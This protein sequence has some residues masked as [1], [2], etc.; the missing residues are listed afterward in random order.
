MNK[1]PQAPIVIF[2]I[3]TIPDVVLLHGTYFEKLNETGKQKAFE[4]F[5]LV[6][7]KTPE[8]LWQMY[9]L[10]PLFTEHANMPAFP[11]P[12]YHCVL[13]VCALF[14]HPETFQI[15]DGWK[16][17]V[18]FCNSRNEFLVHEKKTLKLFWEFIQKHRG[19]SQ[20]WHDKLNS[21]FRMSEFQRKKMVPP[22]VTLS[23]YNTSGFDLPVIEHRSIKHLLPCTF[24]E[25]TSESGYDSYRSKFAADKNFDLC[26]FLFQ[27]GQGKVGLDV[28]A[29][30]V[31]LA[32]K[33]EGMDG[34]KV[35]EEY[36]KNQNVRQI[37]D[38]CAVDVLI[39]YGVFLAVAHFKGMISTS[40]F[41][42]AG[43]HFQKFLE[44]ENRPAVYKQLLFQ[45]ADFF[46]T[47][48]NQC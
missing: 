31:G 30:S 23:G 4:K 10:L 46:E 36:F 20:I 42:E 14:I 48:K 39:T 32:G 1:K 33:M 24:S 15:M 11:A 5:N 26:S 22:P 9:E 28:F 18:P 34:S 27:N 47:C 7:N 12:L 2:D 25:Y 6:E 8:N 40:V 21:D 43:L 3:E 38:Y 13:S 17:T 19:F 37:E 29:R 45:S 35:A 16:Q 41:A 44:A